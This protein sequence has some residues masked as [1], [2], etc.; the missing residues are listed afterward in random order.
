MKKRLKLHLLCLRDAIITVG[1]LVSVTT[2]IWLG[3]QITTELMMRS[4][5]FYSAQEMLRSYN[6]NHIK[7][8]SKHIGGN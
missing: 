2:I 4:E 1:L 8:E 6:G 7:Y 3:Y 5:E